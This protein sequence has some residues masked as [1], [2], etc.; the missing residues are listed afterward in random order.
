MN[1][2]VRSRQLFDFLVCGLPW[3]LR[4][5]RL[6][7]TRGEAFG[8]FV[9]ETGNDG[10]SPVMILAALVATADQW[11]TFSDEWYKVLI[12]K[13]PKPLHKG[14]KGK[15]YYKTTEADGPRGCFAGFTH[16]EADIKTET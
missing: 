7:L 6:I 8:S 4:R 12:G 11:K 1:P 9:D 3:H 13:T 16:E 5:R 15:I 14:K 10:R 2:A